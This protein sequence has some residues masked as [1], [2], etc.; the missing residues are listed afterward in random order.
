[1]GVDNG[2]TLFSGGNA[3]SFVR[4]WKVSIIEIDENSSGLQR[5]LCCDLIPKAQLY[6]IHSLKYVATKADTTFAFWTE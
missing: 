1:M 3:A 2:V 5:A 6:S 4:T